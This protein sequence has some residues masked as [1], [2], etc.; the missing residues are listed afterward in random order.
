MAKI[1]GP[2]FTQ[3]FRKNLLYQG[4]SDGRFEIVQDKASSL[5]AWGWN[6]KFADLDNDEFQD[7]FLVNT[8]WADRKINPSFFYH[9]QKGKG[10]S[11]SAADFNLNLFTNSRS[12]VYVDY[13]L[14][15]DIDILVESNLG[16][17]FLLRN[18]NSTGNSIDFSL[19]NK[20][21]NPTSIGARLYIYYGEGKAQMRE[22]KASGGF[23][24]YGDYKLHFGLGEN[25]MLDKIII[26]WSDGSEQTIPGK[27]FSCGHSY[28]ITRNNT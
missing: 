13:D 14:D 5:G 8:E 22:V 6:A 21:F 10:F 19:R 20:E 3:V 7:I 4:T 24:S 23:K 1:L 16:A 27:E 12:F 9:N 28:T 15:G 11:S 2:E 26:K 25:C 17:I 18:S